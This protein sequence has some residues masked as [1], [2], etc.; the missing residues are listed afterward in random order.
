MLTLE[1]L[2][3]EIKLYGFEK[4]KYEMNEK[5]HIKNKLELEVQ[6]LQNQVNYINYQKKDLGSVYARAS[7]E[8][9]QNYLVLDV[10]SWIKF[11]F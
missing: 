5:L 7:N 10:S 6:N 2:I 3:T 9:S 11:I 8:I 4:L 1:N